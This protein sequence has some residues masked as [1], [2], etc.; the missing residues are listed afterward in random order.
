MRT[1]GG[2]SCR[3]PQAS[4]R[5]EPWP[6]AGQ[7]WGCSEPALPPSPRAGI[8]LVEQPQLPLLPLAQHPQPL[9]SSS[10]PSPH[11]VLASHRAEPQWRTEPG[12]G[13]AP[14]AWNPSREC[15]GGGAS[16][17]WEQVSLGPPWAVAASSAGTSESC[18]AQSAAEPPFPP[19]P[20]GSG[21]AQGTSTPALAQRGHQELPQGPVTFQGHHGLFPQPRAPVPRASSTPRLFLC[22]SMVLETKSHL[23]LSRRSP[24]PGLCQP[25]L[26][27][28]SSPRCPVWPLV[29][30]TSQTPLPKA[31]QE[32]ALPLGPHSSSLFLAAP[33]APPGRDDAGSSVCCQLD[34]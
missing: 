21:G 34:E 28:H 3:T 8:V 25:G 19:A 14:L 9:H 11:Q 32:P 31:A 1:C 26:A 16:P 4:A 5:T 12:A 10:S 18:C 13:L 6:R 20:P 22:P 33:R 27:T 7:A 2:G 15:P 29:A 30:A 24:C 23:L 17:T